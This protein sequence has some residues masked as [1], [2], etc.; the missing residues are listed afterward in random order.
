MVVLAAVGAAVAT[1]PI[2]AVPAEPEDLVAVVALGAAV[3]MAAVVARGEAVVAAALVV[4]AVPPQ[5]L[6]LA[7]L[8]ASA[9]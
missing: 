6:R 3:I 5:L 4:M 7:A 2:A 1:A 9:P 8:A